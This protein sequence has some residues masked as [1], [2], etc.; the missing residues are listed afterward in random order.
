MYTQRAADL[1]EVQ[2]RAADSKRSVHR[3]ELNRQRDD[4]LHRRGE[5]VEIHV[6]PHHFL[7][8]RVHRTQKMHAAIAAECAGSEEEAR[9]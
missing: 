4:A 9:D 8:R 1:G 2:I 3:H 5:L 7:I 6:R